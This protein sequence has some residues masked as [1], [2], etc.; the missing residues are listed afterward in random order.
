[1]TA[2]ASTFAGADRVLPA[3]GAGD[4]AHPVRML[5]KLK[6]DKQTVRRLS[7]V[8]LSDVR[9]ARDADDGTDSGYPVCQSYGS[10]DCPVPAGSLEGP[11]CNGTSGVLC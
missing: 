4:R 9:G 1:V 11:I 6:V 3:G 7:G 2:I 10:C 8:A 5:K